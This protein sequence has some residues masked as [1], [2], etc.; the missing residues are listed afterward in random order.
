LVTIILI[1]KLRINAEHRNLA[2]LFSP[3]SFNVIK[4]EDAAS[5]FL[6]LA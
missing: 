1:H 5:V 2:F 6:A 4:Y 3:R